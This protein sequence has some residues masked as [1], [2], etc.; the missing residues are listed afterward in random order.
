MCGCTQSQ[1]VIDLFGIILLKNSELLFGSIVKSFD[2]FKALFDISEEENDFI[3]EYLE[4]NNGEFVHKINDFVN[5]KTQK[6]IFIRIL[7]KLGSQ[8]VVYGRFKAKETSS[9]ASS[10]KAFIQIKKG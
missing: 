6:A 3:Y 7:Q 9:D 4:S 8:K 10:S 5:F 2:V 1:K